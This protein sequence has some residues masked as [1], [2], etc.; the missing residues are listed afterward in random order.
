M[1][2]SFTFVSAVLQT[3]LRQDDTNGGVSEAFTIEMRYMQSKDSTAETDS[4]SAWRKW[5]HYAFHLGWIF[6]IRMQC[7][8]YSSLVYILYPLKNV[9]YEFNFIIQFYI[10]FLY[11]CKF[12]SYVLYINKIHAYWHDRDE[13]AANWSGFSKLPIYGQ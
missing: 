1:F 7:A 9:L 2:V 6:R 12:Y 3:L 11:R 13:I 8:N 10:P 4:H 5:W